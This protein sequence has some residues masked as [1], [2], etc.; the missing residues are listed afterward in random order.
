MEKFEAKDIAREHA[1]KLSR[2]MVRLSSR[3]IK[4]IHRKQFDQAREI[5][6]EAGALNTEIKSILADHPELY[7][8]GFLEQAQ[9][10]YAEATILYCIIK[11]NRI[12]DTTEID[13]ED[14]AYLLG[15]GDVVGELRRLILDLIRLDTPEEG[16]KY[17]DI[18][19]DMYTT[20]LL[21]DFPDALLRGLRHKGDVARSLVERTR[22]ELTNSIGHAKLKERMSELE[23]K[24]E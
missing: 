14:P 2:T 12:P 10:E 19:D 8:A 5:I 17:L 6:A 20:M 1:L 11:E 7:F 3:A 16:E 4:S 18:M 9:Q 13:V 21:F 22:G 24:L 15:L 23:K